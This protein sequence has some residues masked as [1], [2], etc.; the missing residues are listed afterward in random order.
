MI[1]PATPG[2]FLLML[3]RDGFQR[4]CPVIGWD[5][6]K[7][8]DDET[9]VRPVTDRGTYGL[10]KATRVRTQLIEIR[11]DGSIW[12]GGSRWN[13]EDVDAVFASMLNTWKEEE[14]FE[15]EMNDLQQ[16]RLDQLPEEDE[17]E[18]P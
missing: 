5:V 9:V 1:I 16:A 12:S 14:R 3:N 7:V 2:H 6:R 18:E 10:K 15:E 17:A 4:I 11:G 13:V 8:E